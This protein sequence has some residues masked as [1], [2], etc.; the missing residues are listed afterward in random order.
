[1]TGKAVKE[2]LENLMNT[3]KDVFLMENN[4]QKNG[5]YSRSMKT[6]MGEI[7]DL[8]VPRDRNGTFQTAAFEPYSR[9]IGIDELILALYSKGISTR[10]SAEIMHT[11]FQ[12]RYS[13]S[14]ISTITEATL[15]EVRRFQD[16]PLE[17]RY[18]AVFLDGLF[19][20][21]R[22]DTVEKEPVIFAMRTL[23]GEYEILGF[24]LSA[25]EIH[26]TYSTIIQDL[27]NRGIMEPLLFIADGV[28]KLDEE[29][30]KIF[31]RA[32]FQ[33]CTIHASRNL[34][35]DVRESD[36]N[37]IDRDLK[38]VFLSETKDSAISRF[39][40]FKDKWSSKYP[41]PGYNM[42]K[43]LGYLFTYFQYN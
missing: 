12:N 28:P 8:N 15:E 32:Q 1:V 16:R 14:T 41:R 13:S 30:R 4:G 25:K 23:K 40:H 38:A 24:Y 43:K 31:P 18:I 3:E 39:N 29:I 33:L 35:S 11:I 20:F 26:N 7:R 21:L 19:F 9:S 10:N 36:K 2:F 27:Y 22:R 17:K 5:Y 34:E 42:E 37:E 6:K